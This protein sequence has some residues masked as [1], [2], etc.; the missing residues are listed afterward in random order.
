MTSRCRSH[1][2]GLQSAGKELW[3]SILA[4]VGPGWRLDARDLHFLDQACRI[5]DEMRE[6]ERIVDKEGLTTNGSRGQVTVH[7]ALAEARQLRQVQQRLLGAVELCSAADGTR[8]T[9]SAHASRAA[10]ARW[11]VAS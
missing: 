11:Q 10:N 8:S 6:L 2:T 1:P 5:E 7:P 9:A 3:K 4:D